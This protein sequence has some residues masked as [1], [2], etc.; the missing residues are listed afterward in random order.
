LMLRNVQLRTA[1][2]DARPPLVLDDV[3]LARD[4]ETG[5]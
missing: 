1:V 3:R 2:P 4:Q 5:S